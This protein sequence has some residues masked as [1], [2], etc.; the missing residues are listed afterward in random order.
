MKISVINKIKYLAWNTYLTALIPIF[1]ISAVM[2]RKKRQYFVWG[3]MPLISNKYWSNALKENNLNSISI[4][5]GVFSINKKNDFDKYFD[6]FVPSFIRFLPTFIIREIGRSLAFNFVLRKSKVLHT[7]FNGFALNNSIWWW[8]EPILLKLSGCK[9]IIIP[10]G[11]D[12]YPFSMIQDISLRIGLMD[13]YRKLAFKEDAILK[14]IKQWNKYSDIIISGFMIDSIPRWDVNI[15][16]PFTIDIKEWKSKEEYSS[17]NG[18]NGSVKIIHTSNHRGF[19]G[20]HF[21]INAINNLRKKG[22]LIEFILIE[23]TPNEEIRK[24][25]KTADILV[26]QLI[27]G[28]Y[29]FSGIEGMSSG[30]PVLSN[31]DNDFYTKH[32]YRLSF[33]KECPILS[34]TPENIEENLKLLID[35]PTLRKEIGLASRK[36]VEK[37][38]S[39]NAAFKLFKRIYDKLFLDPELDIMN[40]FHP[41]IGIDTKA[42]IIHPL[43]NNKYIEN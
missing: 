11:G 34:T 22:Y 7:S 37:Y 15:P 6:D 36:Y 39:Q 35:R 9:T 20:T 4:M 27:F 29:A 19:N 1:F 31:L 8:I 25:I 33:L 3:S 2:P 10:F 41:I 12:A 18:R 40:M 38:H 32:H 30:L 23:N 5:E 21:I 28:G 42:K 14:R 17:Y 13:S 43:K 26:E 24:I 16:S